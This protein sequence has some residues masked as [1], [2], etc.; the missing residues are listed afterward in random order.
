MAENKVLGAMTPKETCTDKNCPFHG[1]VNVKGETFSGKVS[2]KDINRSATIEWNR[3][4]YIPKYERYAMKK[5]KMRVHNPACLDAQVGQD[6]VVARARPL[7]KTKH[8]V[9]IK[10][11]T[12][13]NKQ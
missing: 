1:Q 13:E 9:I 4:T 11:V 6:V 3:S 12:E 10:I 8:H 7:S 2:K 5:S